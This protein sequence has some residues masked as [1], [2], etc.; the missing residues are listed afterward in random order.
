[1]ARH[2]KQ[3]ANRWSWPPE[4]WEPR[5]PL[6]RSRKNRF[7]FVA[8]LWDSVRVKAL[9]FMILTFKCWFSCSRSN[10]TC[11]KTKMEN[12][13]TLPV[14]VPLPPCH[15]PSWATFQ[16]ASL[17]VP[18]DATVWIFHWDAF[19]ARRHNEIT[20]NE[21]IRCISRDWRFFGTFEF[22]HMKPWPLG[23]FADYQHF[24]NQLR[25]LLEEKVSASAA[26]FFASIE[27]VLTMIGPLPTKYGILLNIAEILFG[28]RGLYCNRKNPLEASLWWFCIGFSWF[29]FLI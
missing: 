28:F 24:S 29:F 4:K 5:K 16:T 21:L 6:K 27:V 22:D 25:R 7:S 26:L 17:E 13:D 23:G 11:Y 2:T 1:M 19:R 18:A 15:F 8:S 3:S 12:N 9:I 14:F 10:F 20:S